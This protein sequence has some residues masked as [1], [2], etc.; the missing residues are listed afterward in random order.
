M[1]DD[2]G[3]DL[4]V[5]DEVSLGRHLVDDSMHIFLQIIYH[6]HLAR[7]LSHSSYNLG[8]K[9]CLA[10]SAAK[11]DRESPMSLMIES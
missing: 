6:G 2:D 10:C 8:S 3:G 1:D 5:M 7:C 11:I 4:M 9:Y